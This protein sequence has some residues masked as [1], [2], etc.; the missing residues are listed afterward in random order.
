[1][2]IDTTRFGLLDLEEAVFINFPWGI[3]GF[4]KLKRYVLLEHGEGPFQWLQSVDEPSVAFPV[5]PP[6]SLG[7]TYQVPE[8]RGKTISLEK[9]EDLVVLI[10][11]SIDRKATSVRP[12]LRGPLLFNV[13]SRQAYQWTI[14]SRE[15]EKY[16]KTKN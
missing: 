3:P 11:V 9:W 16:I 5:C 6:E 7:F 15:L 13:A 4:E 1:M 10:M 14:D 12:H 2:R 8:D